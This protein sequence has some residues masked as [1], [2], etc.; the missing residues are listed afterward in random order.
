MLTTMIVAG[1]V[2]A[3]AGVLWFVVGLVSVIISDPL[4]QPPWLVM[5]G[6]PAGLFVAFAGGMM[7]G[8]G[9]HIAVERRWRDDGRRGTVTL[10]DLRPGSAGDSSQ[11]LT[12][13]LEIQVPGQDPRHGDHRTSVGPLDAPRMVEGARFP[14]Q[15]SPTVPNRIR[16]WLYTDPDAA[17]LTGRYLDFRPV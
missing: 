17:E 16:V 2:L 5:L 1:V 6:A 3:L 12:C 7:A 13:R 10:S 14:C 9:E 4:D 8:I 15:I 11:E